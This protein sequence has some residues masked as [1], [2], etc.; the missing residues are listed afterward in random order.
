VHVPKN[1]VSYLSHA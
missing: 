1:L